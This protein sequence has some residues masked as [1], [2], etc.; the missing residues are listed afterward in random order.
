MEQK[1]D[2]P[3]SRKKAWKTANRKF[4]PCTWHMHAQKILNI[5][6]WN[7]GWWVIFTPWDF[8]FDY[9]WETNPVLKKNVGFIHGKYQLDDPNF[10]PEVLAS[11]PGKAP[12][13]GPIRVA[14]KW[15]QFCKFLGW[16]REKHILYIYIY[17]YA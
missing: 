16:N 1:L 15:Y 17:L 12:F 4:N 7:G 5:L 9:Q 6:I 11:E 13:A 8:I 14:T 2:I 10:S 3:I